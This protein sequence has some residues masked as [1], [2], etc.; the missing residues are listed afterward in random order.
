MF[1]TLK[2]PTDVQVEIT[3]CCNITMLKFIYNKEEEFKIWDGLKEAIKEPVRSITEKD[4]KEV[5]VSSVTAEAMVAK[6][7]KDW[8]AIEPNFL[9]Q[10][11]K[12]YRRKLEP[13][14]NL[15]AFLVRYY[16]F[17]YWYR[18]EKCWFAV[19]LFTSQIERTRV[20]MHELCHFYQP[21]KLP[22]SV[23]EAIPVILNDHDLF[24]MYREERGH[25][26]PEEQKWR[27]II[28]ESYQKGKSLWD[29]LKE[30]N[31]AH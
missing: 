25:A 28:W 8:L 13:A 2:S 11:G 4:I 31:V 9:T 26:D 1:R 29:I 16:R 27:K 20:I 14:E 30:E 17:P 24:K 10:L 15:T 12:F 5:S 22:E 19:P 23:K 6:V 21:L 3:D 7:E 18:G